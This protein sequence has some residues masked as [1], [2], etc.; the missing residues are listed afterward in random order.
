MRVQKSDS[1]SVT[2]SVRTYGGRKEALL[3][4]TSDDEEISE[5]LVRVF[6][7]H[8]AP[9]TEPEVDLPW[10][11]EDVGDCRIDNESVIL[12]VEGSGG[13]FMGLRFETQWGRTPPEWHAYAERTGRVW[14][15][16]VGLDDYNR[17]T[18]GGWE[19]RLP[20][21]RM[22]KLEVTA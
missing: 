17:L 18:E 12:T 13:A 2:N 9:E 19:A 21:M 10:D 3:L 16:L 6:T 1:A 5:A 11:L 7:I 14:L 4:I 15:G 8:E 20:A 22:L